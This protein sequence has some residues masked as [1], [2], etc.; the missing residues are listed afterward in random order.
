MTEPEAL[1]KVEVRVENDGWTAIDCIALADK[2][3]AALEMIVPDVNWPV[4]ILFTGDAAVKEL[5]EHFRG[6]NKPTNVLSFPTGDVIWSDYDYLGDIAL[7]FETC[8]R[9]ADEKGISLGDHTVHL[10][11]H[12]ML[13]LTGCDHET[14]IEASAM[15]QR[16]INILQRLGVPNPYGQ[17]EAA[18]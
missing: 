18:P 10:I 6:K 9:E 7:A 5:N 1:A 3:F 2:C 4:S 17:A 11:V 14:D 13:H 12:G 8:S 15:E 16:E